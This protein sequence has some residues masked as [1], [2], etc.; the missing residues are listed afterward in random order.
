MGKMHRLG[1]HLGLGE[2]ETH[3]DIREGLSGTAP[4]GGM[5]TLWRRG[6]ESCKHVRIAT[7]R[8]R[9]GCEPEPESGANA[10]QTEGKASRSEGGAG[11][12]GTKAGAMKTSESKYDFQKALGLST[13]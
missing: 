13:I 8:D 3:N 4:R 12:K 5:S 9:L 11:R 2:S 7:H 6:Q 1:L 10:E